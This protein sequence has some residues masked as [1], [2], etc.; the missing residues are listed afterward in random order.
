MSHM[1][2]GELDLDMIDILD[3]VAGSA[4]AFDTADALIESFCR[5]VPGDW[6]DCESLF[7]IGRDH[8]ARYR[9]FCDHAGHGTLR[10]V[11]PLNSVRTP[12]GHW[13]P[14]V[15]ATCSCGS[16][17][18]MLRELVPVLVKQLVQAP[19]GENIATEVAFGASV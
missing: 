11:A 18:A 14:G 13:G 1:T 15:I 7:E 19:G 12:R 2:D 9:W 3:R 4:M 17:L 16:T 5:N 6:P 10:L 8:W